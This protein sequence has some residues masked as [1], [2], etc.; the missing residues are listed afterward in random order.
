MIFCVL[1]NSKTKAKFSS[2]M[3]QHQI[4]FESAI[5]FPTKKINKQLISY[6]S[7][8]KSYKTKYPLHFLN[9]LS[10]NKSSCMNLGFIDASTK[11][12]E[13]A[14]FVFGEDLL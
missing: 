12:S 9:F 2:F 11:C 1:L 13:S 6:F 4:S 10:E 5:K 7:H 3:M 14:D 8:N